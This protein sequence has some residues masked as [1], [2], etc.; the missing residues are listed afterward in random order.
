M[1]IWSTILLL[2]I[3]LIGLIYW[4]K[5]SNRFQDLVFQFTGG[6]IL[7]SLM[8]LYSEEFNVVSSR[9]S[10]QIYAWNKI[11][12]ISFSLTF[13]AN[14]LRKLKP[15]YAKYPTI[16]SFLP[17]LLILVYPLIRES[18]VIYSMLFRLVLGGG[19]LSMVLMSVMLVKK[20]RSIW[21]ISIGAFLLLF[22]YLL[23][24]FFIEISSYHPWTVHTTLSGSIPFCLAAF[25]RLDQHI[26]H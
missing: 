11:I 2:L 21:T 17:L 8:T 1:S 12:L 18:E 23:E 24:W 5:I 4:A 22:S 6:V 26:N 9:I 15:S 3:S 13:L 20:D 10:P 25:K 16:F 19:V 14:L 7:I